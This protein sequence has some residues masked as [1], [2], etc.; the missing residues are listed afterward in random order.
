MSGLQ[1]PSP[2]PEVTSSDDSDL[3]DVFVTLENVPTL[4]TMF[5]EGD[6]HAAAEADFP[7]DATLLDRVSLFQGDITRLLVDSIVN[8]A[9]RSL[10]GGGGVDGVIHAAA[11]PGLLEECRTLGGCETGFTKIST[12]HKLP[13]QHVLHTAAP[14]AA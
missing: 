11:G 1:T 14:R 5:K 7:H 2:D 4:P 13:A 12:G 9:N 3:E 10:L 6:L 8:A